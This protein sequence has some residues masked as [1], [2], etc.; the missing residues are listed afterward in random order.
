MAKALG[1]GQVAEWFKAAVLK[2]QKGGAAKPRNPHISNENRPR[3]TR[4]G[5][6]SKRFALA[7]NPAHQNGLETGL[8]SCP[9]P[10]HNAKGARMAKK[11]IADK[12]KPD[13]AEL[14]RELTLAKVAFQ[15][16]AIKAV[17]GGEQ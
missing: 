4:T 17:L 13:N 15:L 14:I 6:I 8:P 12:Q 7:H 11:P 3:I 16:R 2:T 5:R 10:D 9:S 1:V